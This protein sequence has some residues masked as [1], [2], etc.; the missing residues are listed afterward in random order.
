MVVSPRGTARHNPRAEAAAPPC[1]QEKFGWTQADTAKV[2]DPVMREWERHDAQTRIDSFFEA[3]AADEGRE[4]FAKVKSKR[5]RNAI[6]SMT[7]AG[8]PARRRGW[9]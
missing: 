1:P 2:M 9:L 4:Q 7:G 8:R 5:L 3:Q 6:A